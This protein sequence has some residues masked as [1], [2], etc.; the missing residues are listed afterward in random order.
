MKKKNSDIL[1]LP[2]ETIKEMYYNIIYFHHLVYI[3]YGMSRPIY[4][5]IFILS[6]Y[7]LI[8]VRTFPII[9]IFSD[10]TVVGDNIN[11]I[12]TT[13]ELNFD[14]YQLLFN[15][16]DTQKYGKKKSCQF[17]KLHFNYL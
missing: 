10:T 12:K 7:I 17:K 14:F 4:I 2:F 13:F 11:I 1:K 15:S 6:V 3:F 8:T 5:L 9:L 16:V